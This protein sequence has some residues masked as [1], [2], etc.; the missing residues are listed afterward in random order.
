MAHLCD[1]PGL[2]KA[3][4]NKQ[5]VHKLTAAEVFGIDV[6]SATDEQRRVAKAIN[7]GLMYGM[8]AFGLAKQLG[9][10]RSESQEYI[11]SYFLKYLTLKILYLILEVS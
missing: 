9:I 6:A 5:D 2:I 7:F 3:F 8:S 11:N 4:E 1:D 10:G